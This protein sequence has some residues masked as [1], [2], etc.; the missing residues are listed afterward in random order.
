MM[1]VLGSR[2]ARH[3]LPA[4]RPPA[5]WDL[6]VTPEEIGRIALAYDGSIT[7][8]VP[9]S[10]YKYRLMLHGERMIEVEVVEPGSS[11]A[12]LAEDAASWPKIDTPVGLAH[13]PPLDYLWRI[14]K[15]HVY[16]PVHWDKNIAD[17]HEIGAACGFRP[18]ARAEAFYALR[19]QECEA[20]FGHRRRARLSMSNEAFF[21]KS[22]KA[23]GRVVD[24]DAIH[25]VVAYGERPL[26]EAMKHDLSLAT[27]S[28]DLFEAASE[29][30]KL[31]LVREEAMAIAI[32]RYILTGKV[33][34]GAV[35]YASALKR[36]CTTLT[37]GWF[38][39]FAILNWP[40]LREPDFDFVTRF[41]SSP[42]GLSLRSPSSPPSRASSDHPAPCSP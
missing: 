5:D 2:A 16:W 13:V 7:E 17:L 38:R 32:E 20:K 37:S 41:W 10:P 22:E 1:I 40:A 19:L 8:F 23:V 15:A 29:E 4:F 21:A 3:H 28:R 42:L 31:R 9:S 26:F 6:V 35:A 24:H 36:I 12:L 14:K 25:E 34:E 30:T 39:E 18:H 11:N 33:G 27:L